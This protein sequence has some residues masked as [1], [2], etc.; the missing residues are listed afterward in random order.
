[1][2]WTR[3]STSCNLPASLCLSL[4]VS[5][6]ADL[7]LFS[8]LSLT[9]GEVTCRDGDRTTLGPEEESTSVGELQWNVGGQPTWRLQSMKRNASCETA[10]GFSTQ[11]LLFLSL[12]KVK[13]VM[14]NV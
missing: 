13:S 12:N 4:T 8:F 5:T 9:P 10:I 3:A 11:T 2:E 7:M 6:S 1:M 14:F